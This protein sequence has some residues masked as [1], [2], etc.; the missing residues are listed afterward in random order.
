MP[1]IHSS[2]GFYR[3]SSLIGLLLLGMSATGCEQFTVIK[4]DKIG[5]VPLHLNPSSLSLGFGN[6]HQFQAVGGLAPFEFTLLQG[7]GGQITHDQ[8]AYIAASQVGTETVQV[9]D[10]QGTVA[11]AT[12]NIQPPISISPPTLLSTVGTPHLFQG[13]GGVPPYEFTVRTTGGGTINSGTGAYVAPAVVPDGGTATIRVADS[14]G[15]A[16]QA[17]VTLYPAIQISP[18]TVARSVNKTISFSAAGGRPPYSYSVVVSGTGMVNATGGVYTAPGSV[19]SG[20]K[21]TVRVTDSLSSTSDSM[22]S[23]Y[24]SVQISPTAVTLPAGQSTPFSVTGGLPPYTF[25]VANLGGSIVATTGA[26][27]APVIPPASGNT[28]VSVTDSIGNVSNATVTLPSN[29]NVSG[30]V[31]DATNNAALAGVSVTISI[32]GA[33]TSVATT[34]T[35]AAGT[36]SFANLLPGSYKLDFVK[37]GYV[38]LL[39]KPAA[40]VSGQ[41]T[42]LDASLSSVLMSN[43]FRFVLTWGNA[44]QGAPS[45][46][47]SWLV[48]PAGLGDSV[49]YPHRNGVGAN[50][51]VDDTNYSGPETMTITTLYPGTYVYIVNDF[52][53]TPLL[54][55]ALAEV[56]VYQ[57]ANI[58]R[59][60][61]IPASLLS[62]TSNYEVCRIVNGV[63]VDSGRYVTSIANNP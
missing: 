58:V 57:G 27:T 44:A 2:T 20:G 5:T 52:S 54:S 26:Y 47:D 24:P 22:V 48:L 4:V 18:T 17:T 46:L 45:D 55:S 10:V 60:Y 51:D 39:A 50:L 7:V 37:T 34:A 19:P 38:S 15:N 12:V 11:I 32:A 31:R 43:Q 3:L 63:L 59:T 30:T 61:T 9:K 35:S 6:R 62:T 23:I 13:S 25:A 28:T 1:P 53:R 16:T 40:S 21:A 29:G 14:L 8:G 56:V 33:T 49:G 42:V 41:T 36:Y